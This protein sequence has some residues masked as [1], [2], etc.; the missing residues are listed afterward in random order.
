M[1]DKQT[2]AEAWDELHKAVAELSRTFIKSGG[3][4]VMAGIWIG[5]VIMLVVVLI[6]GQ[7]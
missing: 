3:P 5:M 7:P 2:M 6:T 1:G 4:Q